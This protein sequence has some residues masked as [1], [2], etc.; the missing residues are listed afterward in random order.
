[1][2]ARPLLFLLILGLAGPAVA[3][4]EE[5]YKLGEGGWAAAAMEPAAAP[6]RDVAAMRALLAEGRF[7]E[8]E[9]AA[10][11]WLDATPGAAAEADVLLARGDARVGQNRL[12]RALYDYERLLTTHPGSDAYLEAVSRELAIAKLFIGGWKRKLL[13]VRVL[14]TDGEGAELLVRVQERAPGSDLAEDAAL[15]LADHFF[16]KQQMAQAAEM[17][18]LLLRNFPRTRRGSGRC[19]GRSRRGWRSSRDP[20]STPPACWRPASG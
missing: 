16:A 9:A 13:G 14:P 3:R 2:T 20:T 4:A 7:D 17:Y 5:V 10:S 18:D 8:A 6:D 1:M 11:A 12:W 19:S 15:T